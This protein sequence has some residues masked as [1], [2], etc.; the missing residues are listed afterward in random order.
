[1]IT[2]FS[3]SFS[4]FVEGNR[5]EIS[6]TAHADQI[7]IHFRKRAQ[8]ANVIR[9]IQTYQQMPFYFH[10]V[11]RLRDWLQQS[12]KNA[13][14]I[15]DDSMYKRSL[16]LEPR[17]ST[18][19]A[20]AKANTALNSSMSSTYHGSSSNN[21]NN[22][23]NDTNQMSATYGGS[24]KSPIPESPSKTDNSSASSERSLSPTPTRT[25][26]ASPQPEGTTSATTSAA[27]VVED[28]TPQTPSVQLP[29]QQ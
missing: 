9:D 1:M 15:D 16:V 5:N 25:T 18:M 24:S 21:D 6:S 11:D 23:N 12:I 19:A 2:D 20:S 17:D 3:L 29:Q 13:Q 27:V 14:V 26:I 7:L 4:L 28:T 22:N 10:S 8:T